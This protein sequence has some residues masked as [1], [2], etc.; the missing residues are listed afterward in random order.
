MIFFSSLLL[1]LGK[2]ISIFFLIFF[3]FLISGPIFLKIKQPKLDEFFIPIILKIIK[4]NITIINS[5]K[6]FK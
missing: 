6:V 1:I 2:T 5:K 4:K 3:E